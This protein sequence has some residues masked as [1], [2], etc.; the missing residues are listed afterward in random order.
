MH[1]DHDK[2]R[3]IVAQRLRK[4]EEE[5]NSFGSALPEFKNRSKV[6]LIILDDETQEHEFGWVFFYDSR[7][8]IESGDDREMLA[9]NAP[10]IVDKTDGRLYVT[11]TAHQL[12]HYLD[13]FQRG[14]RTPA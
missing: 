5:M 7:E 11:G 12:E 1:I 4:D 8:H 6:H 13:E 10:Y 14:N 2:A 3:E 9:G